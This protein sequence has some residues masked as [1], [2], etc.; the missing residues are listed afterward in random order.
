MSN[1]LLLIYRQ[2]AYGLY[3]DA[4]GNQGRIIE[5]LPEVLFR[6]IN[7]CPPFSGA[8]RSQRLGDGNQFACIPVGMG[9]VVIMNFRAL[10]RSGNFAR[11]YGPGRLRR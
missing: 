10:D 4:A 7:L 6:F 8:R 3:Y 5:K 9:G 2:I 11:P 1:R